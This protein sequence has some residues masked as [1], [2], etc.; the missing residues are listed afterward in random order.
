MEG[1][2]ARH[3]PKL[4]A[5]LHVVEADDAAVVLP[6]LAPGRRVQ[7][8]DGLLGSRDAVRVPPSS[9]ASRMSK[10]FIIEA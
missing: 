6:H 4:L 10:S 2:A 3:H 7:V 1:M 5:D 9:S 8:D